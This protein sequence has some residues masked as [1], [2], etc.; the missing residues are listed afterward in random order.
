[1]NHF[2][3]ALSNLPVIEPPRKKARPPAKK[4]W[5]RDASQ[6]VANDC[7]SLCYSRVLPR[8]QVALVES[9]GATGRAVECS[10]RTAWLNFWSNRVSHVSFTWTKCRH[11]PPF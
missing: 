7:T 6:H 3:P 9:Y 1:M 2:M 11:S 10:R 5:G 4:L 8:E